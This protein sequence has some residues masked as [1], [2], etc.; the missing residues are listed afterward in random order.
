MDA[1]AFQRLLASTPLP[2]APDLSRLTAAGRDG[3]PALVRTGDGSLR[4]GMHVQL[5]RGRATTSIGLTAVGTAPT[6]GN[7][8]D[9]VIVDTAT[10]AAAGLTA[11]PDT[12]WVTGPGAARAVTATAVD[13]HAEVRADVLR[14]RRTAPLTSSLVSLDRAAAAALLILG[15][16]GFALG[17]AASA[18]DRW[19]TLARLRTLGLRPRDARRVAAAELLPPVVL[20]ALVGPLLAVLLVRLTVGPLALHVLTGQTAAPRS[21]IAWWGIGTAGAA[22]LVMLGAV[23]AA[24]AALRRRRRLGDVLR[25]G[26]T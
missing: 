15:L 19:E 9:V 6:V 14:E 10:A 5:S 25:A 21:V 8:A 16:L 1:A 11:V 12:V 17:A 7:A 3:I 4:P 18:P 20:A 13:A 26:T 23:V 2:D 24:E 22:L